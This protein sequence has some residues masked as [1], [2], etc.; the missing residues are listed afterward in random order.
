MADTVASWRATPP[1]WAGP[2][3]RRQAGRWALAAAVAGA[4]LLSGAW[5]R[6]HLDPLTPTTGRPW[7]RLG[8]VA[9]PGASFGVGAGHPGVVLAFSAAAVSALVVWLARAGRRLRWIGLAMALGG[10]LGNLADRIADGA[11]TDWI[12]LGFYPATFNLADIAIRAGLALALLDVAFT[13]N[14]HRRRRC[15]L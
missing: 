1:R 7:L 10:G 14:P 4:D 11:V 15:G 13:S 8:L 9:N 12:H 6:S 3:L 5:A 2:A